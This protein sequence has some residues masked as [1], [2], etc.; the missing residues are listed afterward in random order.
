MIENI[1]ITKRNYGFDQFELGYVYNRGIDLA[2][3]NPELA[4]KYTKLIQSHPYFKTL[5]EAI[6]FARKQREESY[7]HYQIWAKVGKDEEFFYIQDYYIVT[8]DNK[9]A[10]A[11]D[12][13]GMEQIMM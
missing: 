10:V 7:D 5:D 1:D 11:A 12:Y 8:K 2:N 13:I 4:D 6:K 3:G 9:I